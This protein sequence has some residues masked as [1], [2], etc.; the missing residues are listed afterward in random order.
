MEAA[1][2]LTDLKKTVVQ[3]VIVFEDVT[4][5]SFCGLLK[6]STPFHKAK[7]SFPCPGAACLIFLKTVNLLRDS[8]EIESCIYLHA[9]LIV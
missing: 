6:V 4:F 3:P 5:A 9:G 7:A 8:M 2:R 1:L